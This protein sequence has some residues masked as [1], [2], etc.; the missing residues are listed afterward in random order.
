LGKR[1]PP[2]IS[3]AVLSLE[4]DR[5]LESIVEDITTRFDAPMAVISIMLPHVQFF[6]A[7]RG[8]PA[9]L[10]AARATDRD[11]SFCQVVVRDRA[12]FEVC[13]ALVDE[14]VPRE[15]VD[16]YGLR[17]YMGSPVIVRGEAIGTVCVMDT[18]PRRF[19]DL[20]RAALERAAALA[21]E[22]LAELADA[23]DMTLHERAV[24]PQFAELR[25]RMQPMVGGVKDM[26]IALAELHAVHRI[27]EYVAAH[28]EEPASSVPL[29][30]AA[31]AMRDLEEILADLAISVTAVQR[32]VE[33]LENASF[34]TGD[35]CNV[36]E[37]VVSASTLAHHYT[38]L[39]GGV[40]WPVGLPTIP[41]S[42]PLSLA[43]NALAAALSGL[44]SDVWRAKGKRGL[45]VAIDRDPGAVT[46]R[47]L[48]PDLGRARLAIAAAG[49]SE[50]VEDSSM[51][52]VRHD[53]DGLELVFAAP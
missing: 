17:S 5:E 35:T 48:A 34:D 2:Q 25:N 14:R 29:E 42:V 52:H 46:I 28:P 1:N 33:A 22:R 41:V 15:L 4:P 37:I 43:V 49:L 40:R 32:A 44:S 7:M 53:T 24:R 3:G 50:L 26:Q 31:E 39:I 16:R 51:L 20:Q 9:E 6:R 38:K 21:G 27:S 13:D 12:T 23:P 36:E 47:L 18:V 45:A 8:L 11:V 30:S 10:A 19:D